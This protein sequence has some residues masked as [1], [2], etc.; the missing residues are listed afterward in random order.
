MKSLQQYISESI[1]GD[2]NKDLENYVELDNRLAQELSWVK[3]IKLDDAVHYEAALFDCTYNIFRDI[4][5]RK[6]RSDQLRA[7]ALFMKNAQSRFA[8][9]NADETDGWEEREYDEAQTDNFGEDI[10]QDFLNAYKDPTDYRW[11]WNGSNSFY[12]YWWDPD[13]VHS[14]DQEDLL[15]SKETQQYVK[16]LMAA[17]KH[18]G[19]NIKPIF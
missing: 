2:F 17:L 19:I 1:L 14:L 11:R 15:V 12:H 16:R 9:Y 18:C 10:M 4:T 7:F 5:S 3:K 13:Y 6:L 8:C